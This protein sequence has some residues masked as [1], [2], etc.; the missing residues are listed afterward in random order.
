MVNTGN[1]QCTQVTREREDGKESLL[2]VTKM[3]IPVQKYGELTGPGLVSDMA[4]WPARNTCLKIYFME[5]FPT[6]LAFYIL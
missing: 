5:H 3:T 1:L 4:G 6:N 2:E